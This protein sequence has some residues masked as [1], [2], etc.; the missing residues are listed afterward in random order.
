MTSGTA[1]LE[2]A[3][4]KSDTCCR[5][6][7]YTD[8]NTRWQTV[9]SRRRRQCRKCHQRRKSVVAKYGPVVDVMVLDNEPTGEFVMDEWLRYAACR[10]ADPDGFAAR[11]GESG[12]P[13]RVNAAANRL[14]ASCPVFARC[15]VEA[16]Q[17]RF[18]GLWGG[19][20]RYVDDDGQYRMVVLVDEWF[21]VSGKGERKG[22]DHLVSDLR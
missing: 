18:L 11:D 4:A 16:T 1:M 22:G 17:D 2:S 8:A 7:E 19:I 21:P 3:P 14:C 9:G 13:D 12:V 10:G 20:W 15:H 6:H 5:G